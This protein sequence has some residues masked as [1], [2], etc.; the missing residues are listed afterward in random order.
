MKVQNERKITE[1]KI[2]ERKIAE[3]KTTER[4]ITESHFPSSL[5]VLRMIISLCPELCCLQLIVTDVYRR[6][7][8]STRM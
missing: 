8:R 1:R 3:R 5:I 7:I 2:A 6:V 4:K